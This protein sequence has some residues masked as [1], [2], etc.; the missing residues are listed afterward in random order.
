MGKR[1]RSGKRN[2]RER[3]GRKISCLLLLQ[4][5][6]EQINRRAAVC[7][8]IVLTLLALGCRLAV[9]SPIYARHL[10]CL[11][12]FMPPTVCL[13]LIGGL[14]FF[15]LGALV[16]ALGSTPSPAV[17]RA[18]FRGLVCLIPLALFRLFWYPLFF[19]AISPALALISLFLALFALLAA[20]FALRCVFRLALPVLLMQFAW[21]FWLICANFFVLLFN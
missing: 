5:E 7:G 11:P 2:G 18:R 20:F 14:M 1:K 16:A 19:A 9:G 3:N 12:P 10:L 17:L 21:L 6:W 4:C 13:Y 8:G 15:L